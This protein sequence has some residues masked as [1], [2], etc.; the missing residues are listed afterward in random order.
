MDRPKLRNVSMF[1][2]QASG[3]QMI[4]IQDPLRFSDKAIIVS[5]NDFFIISFFDGKHSILDIQEQYTRKYGDILFSDRVRKLISMLDSNFLLESDGFEQ[6]KKLISEEFNASS[7]RA[8]FHAGGAYESD[9]GRLKEQL[10]AFF[11]PPDGPGE[12]ETDFAPSKDVKGIVAPHIDLARGGSCYAWAYKEIGE[13]CN[14]DLFIIFG[15]SHSVSKNAFTLTNKDFQTPLG[16]MPTDKDLVRSLIEG[17]SADPFEDELI[18]KFEHSI[19]FQVV[20][21]QYVL[22]G[23]KNVR[24][25]PIL[26]SSFHEMIERNIIPSKFP[27]VSD[28]ISLLKEAVVQSG[29]SVCYVAGADLSHVGRRFGD[30]V[31]LTS[32]LLEVIKN[33][34]IEMLEYVQRLDATGF[35]KSIQKDGDDRKICGLPPIYMLLSVIE[36]SQGK[37]LKY[38]QAPEP[39]TGSVVSFA[40]LSFS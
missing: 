11:P 4:C 30:Q 6:Q 39:N 8:T 15:T 24:I 29:R 17:Y 14:A 33:R 21:L 18:H 32:S 2:V 9:P 26:C 19:E 13:R 40:S 10:A 25:V 3:R 20:F 1:P 12:L 16:I 36:A 34:D 22:R 7:V 35:F 31:R 37:V 38:S 23:R 5:Q 28:F 27:A